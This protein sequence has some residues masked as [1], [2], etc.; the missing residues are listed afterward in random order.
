MSERG[1]VEVECGDPALAASSFFNILK[2]HGVT[3]PEDVH[4]DI[5]RNQQ[6]LALP[7]KS[8]LPRAVTGRMNDM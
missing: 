5:T 1:R 2:A 3:K 7:E 4:A 8:D 6:S